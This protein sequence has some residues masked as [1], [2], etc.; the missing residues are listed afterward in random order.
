MKKRWVNI[1]LEIIFYIVILACVTSEIFSASVTD[2]DELWNYNTARA[3]MHGLIPYKEISMITTP[4]LP[5]IVSI[6][7]KIF[8]DKLIVFR[9]IASVIVTTI[10]FLSYITTK[11]LT[12]NKTY[13]VISALAILMVLNGYYILDY[14]VFIIMLTLIIEIVEILKLE[15]MAQNTN[16]SDEKK[17]DT[18]NKKE[19]ANS[20]KK[21]SNK[22]GRANTIKKYKYDIIIGLLLGLAILT[23]QTI[24]VFVTA[25]CV[26]SE[27]ALVDSKETFKKYIKSSAVKIVS[28]MCVMVCFLLYLIITNSFTD[29]IDYAVL[30]IRT[31]SNKI[32]Y[33]TLFEHSLTKVRRLSKFV[34]LAIVFII[35]SGIV[36]KIMQAKKSKFYKKNKTNIEKYMV[37]FILS[38]GTLITIYPISD[39]THFLIGITPVLVIIISIILD[40][41]N[42][43]KNDKLARFSIY[44]LEVFLILYFSYIGIRGTI[45]NYVQYAISEKPTTIPYF[46]NAP[47]DKE[48]EEYYKAIAEYIETKRTEGY[49]VHMLDAN[50]VVMSVISDNYSKN[51][52]MFLKGNIGKDGEDGI[53]NEIQ[54]STSTIYLVKKRDQ[55][56]N[57][58]TPT[59]VL[60]Y[61]RENLKSIDEIGAYE[62]F[63]KE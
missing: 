61:V 33:S 30:G 6:I 41:L 55:K 50:A 3:I 34:P 45:E 43:A 35:I 49:E 51:Y 42:L 58:Q 16:M 18:Q 60:E 59:K 28:M 13:G 19:L 5:T 44:V 21:D 46:E 62:V 15:K 63:Y 17:N 22:V 7:L 36:L 27:I 37:C 25:F 47:L 53:I 10:V 9:A 24:G 38:L 32:E 4:L 1:I 54:N 23:K 12:K 56:L 2:L 14:N 26:L 52:D 20:D 48:S 11:K 8:G 31:F 57:W 40:T 29:F 39:Q